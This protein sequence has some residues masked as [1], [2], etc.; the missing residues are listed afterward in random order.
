M[1]RDLIQQVLQVAGRTQIHAVGPKVDTRQD[2]LVVP[3]RPQM[4]EMPQDLFGTH[5]AAS[6]TGIGYD[7][8][9]AEA[10][11]SVLDFQ[12]GP[13]ACSGGGDQWFGKGDT[14]SEILHRT[15]GG[16]IGMGGRLDDEFGQVRFATVAHNGMHTLDRFNFCGGDLSVTSGDN[17]AGARMAALQLPNHLARL[18]GRFL[19]D[20]AR[21]HDAD[22][23]NRAVLNG[24]PT[25]GVQGGGKD[26]GFVL[27]DF[28]S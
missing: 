10:V 19:G 1:G 17:D 9:S 23:R 3:H 2:D 6:P 11:A 18:H 20:G 21:V 26:I 28:T 24:L 25:M 27:V 8:V 13:G 14:G 7:T 4:I 5:A 15:I 16:G 22:I 12:K